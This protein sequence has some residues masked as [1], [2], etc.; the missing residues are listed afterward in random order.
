[1]D[2]SSTFSSTTLPVLVTELCNKCSALSTPISLSSSL[3]VSSAPVSPEGARHVL[4]SSSCTFTV[5]ITS[6]PLPPVLEVSSWDLSSGLIT[7]TSSDSSSNAS[8]ATVWQTLVTVL[9]N[10]LSVSSTTSSFSS[11]FLLSCAPVSAPAVKHVLLSSSSTSTICVSFECIPSSVLLHESSHFSRG[12]I[13]Q[14][15][16]T[17]SLTTTSP[18]VCDVTL[19]V[20]SVSNKLSFSSTCTSCPELAT[21]GSAELF[22]TLCFP[23]AFSYV[24]M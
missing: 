5:S 6:S 14:P 17:S 20:T 11:S 12:L 22:S 21:F 18:T 19:I 3:H 1:M 15:V 16:W 7:D 2:P 4:L 13:T 24:S 10:K 8:P 9:S 23:L